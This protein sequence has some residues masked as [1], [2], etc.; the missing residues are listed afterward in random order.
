MSQ[1][2]CYCTCGGTLTGRAS[3]G[4]GAAY[5]IQTFWAVHDGDGHG[6]TDAKGA[7]AARRRED[8]RLAAQRNRHDW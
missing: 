5:L 4:G 8:R 7:A 3:G 2:A 1:L 6:P